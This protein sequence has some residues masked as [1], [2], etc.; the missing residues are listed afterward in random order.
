[1]AFALF[2]TGSANHGV[3]RK[4]TAAQ[5]LKRDHD[6]AAAKLRA[7]KELDWNAMANMSALGMGV[8]YAQKADTCCLFVQIW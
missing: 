8:D 5:G 2:Q 3:H 6:L 4:Q 7:Q 1:M